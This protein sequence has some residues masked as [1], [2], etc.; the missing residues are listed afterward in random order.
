MIYGKDEYAEKWNNSAN[1]LFDNGI[2]EWVTEPLEAYGKV[3]EIGCGTGQSTFVLV[4]KDHTVFA[5]DKNQKCIEKCKSFIEGNDFSVEEIT[6][7]QPITYRDSDVT[8]LNMDWLDENSRLLNYLNPDVIIL[9][10]PGGWNACQGNLEDAENRQLQMIDAVIEFAKSKNIPLSILNRFEN[11]SNAQD[12]WCEIAEDGSYEL[13]K[14]DHIE[15]DESEINGVPLLGNDGKINKPI[16]SYGFFA[17][18][19]E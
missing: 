11:L 14:T 13:V 5:I 12:F 6:I 8:L 3:L 2:Y 1:L 17:K 19:T 16:Y 7:D 4:A 9:W 15:V 18:F 10:N